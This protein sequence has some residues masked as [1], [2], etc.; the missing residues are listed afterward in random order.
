MRTMVT[1]QEEPYEV[2]AN[3]YY[4]KE[5]NL[6]IFLRFFVSLVEEGDDG[7]ALADREGSI[8]IVL[9]IN[10]IQK[11]HEKKHRRI[12]SSEL[13]SF[14]FKHVLHVLNHLLCRYTGHLAR[15][16]NNT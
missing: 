7:S 8:E 15:E 16:R 12:R 5:G 2:I 6:G 14:A 11:W 1:E 9:L 13:N 4:G 10:G 3:D